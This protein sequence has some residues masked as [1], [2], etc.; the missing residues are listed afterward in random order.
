MSYYTKDWKGSN[1]PRLQK[2]LKSIELHRQKF[3]SLYESPRDF[4][5]PC[6][7]E[8]AHHALNKEEFDDSEHGSPSQEG[9]S[10]SSSELDG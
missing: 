7:A 3:P 10:E 8:S 5:F 2:I 6:D 9:E 4:G 1:D